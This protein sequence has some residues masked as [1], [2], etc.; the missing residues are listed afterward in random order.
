MKSEQIQAILS[1]IEELKALFVLGQRVIPFLEEL[2]QFVQEIAPLLEKIN[3]S[4]KESHLQIPHAFSQL[5]RVSQTTE[6]ATTEILDNIDILLSNIAEM[7]AQLRL[8]LSNLEELKRVDNSINKLIQHK[9]SSTTPEAATKIQALSKEKQHFLQQALK[10]VQAVEEHINNFHEKTTNIMMSLQMHDIT[11]QQ[12]ASVSHLIQSVETR[13]KQ[14]LENFDTT[15]IEKAHIYTT[16]L[17]KTFDPFASY[18][19]HLQKQQEAN[20][21]LDLTHTT[22]KLSSPPPSQKAPD[23]KEKGDD[24][25]SSSKSKK[26][27]NDNP[28]QRIVSQDEIDKLFEKNL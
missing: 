14:L 9:F 5:N 28:K 27:D 1:K 8:Q 15:H 4:L 24:A 13:L 26:Q 17:Q 16:Q 11:S 12:I 25:E 7:K 2:F 18:G 21:L 10:N 3:L 22:T 19:N 6:V 20:I 23:N